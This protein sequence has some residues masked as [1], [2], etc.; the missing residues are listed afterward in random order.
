MSLFNEYKNKN[1]FSNSSNYIERNNSFN[2]VKNKP[3]RESNKIQKL[4]NFNIEN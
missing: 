1:E 4:S 3:V 2:I